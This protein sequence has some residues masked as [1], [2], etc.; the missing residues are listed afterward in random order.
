[1]SLPQN[2]M[3]WDCHSNRS[4]RSLANHNIGMSQVDSAWREALKR[5]DVALNGR[6]TKEHL[7]NLSHSNASPLGDSDLLGTRIGG[8]Y[9]YLTGQ[10]SARPQA[11]AGRVVARPYQSEKGPSGKDAESLEKRLAKI[12][13]TVDSLKSENARLRREV[14][15][16]TTSRSG[17]RGTGR[18][19]RSAGSARE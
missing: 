13:S 18:S 8:K 4:L 14:A 10:F 1:M 5:E 15:G 3:V 17:S 19:V 7:S 12:E 16:M 11:S 2:T 6:W 9:A